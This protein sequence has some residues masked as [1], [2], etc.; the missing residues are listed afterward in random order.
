MIEGLWE[1]ARRTGRGSWSARRANAPSHLALFALSAL[2]LASCAR[3][4]ASET[5][6][7]E[8]PLPSVRTALVSE[9][10]APLVLRLS[11]SL[12]GLRE[13]DL[14]ANASGRVTKTFVERGTRVKAGQVLAQLDVRTASISAAEARAHAESARAQAAQLHGECERYEQLKATGT[15]TDLAYERAAAGCRSSALSA[16]ASSARAQLAAQVVGDG[17]IRAPFAGVVTERYVEVGEYLKQDSRVVSLVSM[18]KLRLE[19]AVPELQASA[20]REGAPV[21]FRVAGFPERSY[22]GTV[23]FISGGIREATRDLIVE[24][25][26]DNPDGSL[27]PGMFAEIELGLGVRKLPGL[28]KQAIF[29]RAARKRAFFVVGGRLEERVLSTLPDTEA[30]VPVLK[31]A[32]PGERVALGELNT[33]RNG[34][35]VR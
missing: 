31:G 22:E 6:V 13:A 12:R 28:P 5:G 23:K 16:D 15:V 7:R 29:E 2:W 9:L 19:F 4:A 18:D 34:Q 10:E 25:L 8:A 21:S 3:G 1:R 26:A 11:G 32:K 24:A 14:A 33:L 20:V 17:T 30:G 27:R 35:R